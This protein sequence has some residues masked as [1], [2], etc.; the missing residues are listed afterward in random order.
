[1]LA[2]S[3]H[4]KGLDWVKKLL[5]HNHKCGKFMSTVAE[6]CPE[7]SFSQHSSLSLAIAFFLPLLCGVP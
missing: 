4:C 3:V 1:M 5:G 2:Y 6:S 7:D